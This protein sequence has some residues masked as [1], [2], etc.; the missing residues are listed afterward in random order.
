MLNKVVVLEG[1]ASDNF[2]FIIFHMD[3]YDIKM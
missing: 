3:M 1:H 2:A